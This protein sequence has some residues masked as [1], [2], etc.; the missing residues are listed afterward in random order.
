MCS[1]DLADLETPD[2]PAWGDVT[3][4]QLA[5]LGQPEYKALEPWSAAPTPPALKLQ[6]D[7]A[8]VSW[9]D[10]ADIDAVDQVDA[11]LFP[12]FEEEAQELLPQLANQTREWLDMPSHPAAAAA[13]LRT[14][15]TFKGGA[16]L[17][18]AMRLGELAHQ[19]ESAI[20]RL[21]ASGEPTHADV[22]PLESRVDRLVEVFEAQIGRAHV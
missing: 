4:S 14:L 11:E 6:G 22:A 3:P 21:I 12:I 7:L 9:G 18:G 20:E 8:E 16:R 17:A 5:T 13:C 1:S 19:L 15:H 2:A 10:E